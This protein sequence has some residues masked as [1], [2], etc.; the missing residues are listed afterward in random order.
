M[1]VGSEW[2]G[3]LDQ[4]MKWWGGGACVRCESGLFMYMADPCICI[5]Y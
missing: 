1:G 4:G 2:V 5:L 3:G